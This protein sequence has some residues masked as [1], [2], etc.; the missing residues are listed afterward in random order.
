MY[1]DRDRDAWLHVVGLPPKIGR[2][3]FFP[4]CGFEFRIQTFNH[5]SGP[6]STVMF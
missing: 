3:Q 1:D 5:F 6:G 2:Q 4:V